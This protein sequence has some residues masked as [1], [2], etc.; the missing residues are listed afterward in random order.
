MVDI[1]R[2]LTRKSLNRIRLFVCENSVSQSVM[3]YCKYGYW[4]G[5]KEMG[6]REGICQT[7]SRIDREFEWLNKRE[8]TK[9]GQNTRRHN[10]L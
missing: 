4:T 6:W 5:L 9:N 8:V 2:E 7:C 1:T 3:T 10:G